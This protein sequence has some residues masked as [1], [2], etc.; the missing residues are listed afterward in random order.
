MGLVNW[1]YSHGRPSNDLSRAGLLVHMEITDM[2][3]SVPWEPCHSGWCAHVWREF[4][5]GSIINVRAP[6]VYARGIGF[7]LSP[8][9][10]IVKCAY[11]HDAGSQGSRTG[12]D[13]P[14]CGTGPHMAHSHTVHLP[15]GALLMCGA[16]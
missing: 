12:C 6:A 13:H 8:S 15:L 2:D 9:Q 5:A 1:R 7:L 14:E 16:P 4:L 11:K 3:G 10:Q